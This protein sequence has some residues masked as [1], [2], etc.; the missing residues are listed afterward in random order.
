MK[1]WLH[2]AV[3]ED[4]MGNAVVLQDAALLHILEKPV[5][6]TAYPQSALVHIGIEALDLAAAVDL[7]LDNRAGGGHFLSFA[8][9][10]WV[11]AEAG[12]NHARRHH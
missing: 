11:G 5:V 9:A 3:K 10:L 8:G 2:V 1:G 7:T 6:R 12:N 4:G